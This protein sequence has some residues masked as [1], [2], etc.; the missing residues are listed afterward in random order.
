MLGGSI[1]KYIYTT[2]LDLPRFI[3]NK[4][5]LSYRVTEEVV[6]HSEFD[7]P[8]VRAALTDL[9]WTRPIN[10]ATMADLPG[11]TGLGS[12]SAFTVG[13][14]KLLNLVMGNKLSPLELVRQ[15][16]RLE[17]DILG[18]QVGIQDHLHAAFGGFSLYHLSSD[19]IKVEPL[20]FSSEFQN[21]FNKELFLVYTG[22]GRHASAVA[23]TQINDTKSKKNHTQSLLLLTPFFART[24]S[25][26]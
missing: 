25:S 5:K 26:D 12:S 6:D 7:H 2:C 11:G 8:V 9:S 20:G 15:A 24:P 14:I 21:Q 1:N 3:E 17:H 18:E 23:E 16:Y 13:L 22:T 10:L 4:Y 19:S